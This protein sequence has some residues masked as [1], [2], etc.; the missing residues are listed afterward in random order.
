MLWLLLVLSLLLL[1]LDGRMLRVL[2]CCGSVQQPC[3]Q[4]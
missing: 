3:K 1:L 4:Q 2:R